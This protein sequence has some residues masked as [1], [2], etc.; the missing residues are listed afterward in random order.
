MS[1]NRTIPDDKIYH[2]NTRKALS[3]H[4]FSNREN[5]FQYAPFEREIA[6][7]ESVRSGNLEAVKAMFT[8]LGGEG[9]GVLSK[10]PLQNLKYHLVVSIAM[11]TRFCINSG[12]PPEEAYSLSDIYIRQTDGCGSLDEI[13]DIHYTMTIEFTKRMRQI[14]AAHVYSK[15]I[16][17]MLDYISD[18]L[19]EKLL[20][21][22]IAD[23]V[24]CTVPYISRLFK[25]EMH[26]P[27]STYIMQKKIEAAADMLHFSDYSALEISNYLNFSS[28]SYF[29]KQFRKYT[30]I[31]PKEYRERFYTVGWMK[32]EVKKL[33]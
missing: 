26:T 29:I 7:Y 21:Q 17:K 6:F 20:V 18:H 28:Q 14:Q 8:P 30:G 19:H 31:T 25:S 24:G 12:M 27:I 4:L 10:D 16:V 9:F 5:G 3:E 2:I 13:H 15:T 1:G 33:P 22:D 32:K 23:Y 11:I